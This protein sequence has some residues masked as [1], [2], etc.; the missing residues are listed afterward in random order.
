MSR[1]SSGLEGKSV[2]RIGTVDDFN[3]HEKELRPRIEQFVKDRVGWFEGGVGAER[4]EGGY[5]Q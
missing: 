1:V 3:L 2:L 5:F 4:H